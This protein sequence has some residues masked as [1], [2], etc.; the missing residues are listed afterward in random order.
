LTPA[1][2]PTSS[3]SERPVDRVFLDANVLFS[4]AYAPD[5]RLR[6]LWSLAGV[7]LVTSEFALEEARRNLVLHQ[8]V[9]VA[10]LDELLAGMTITSALAA[11]GCLPPDLALAEK[12]RPILAAAVALG[13]THLLTGDTRHFGALYGRRV[14]GVRILTPAAYLH[15]R[16]ARP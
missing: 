5:S 6:S 9:G 15:D 13:C 1:Q 16:G 7:E 12:D 10:V 3:P 2:F 8:S 11:E 14:Q 4:A